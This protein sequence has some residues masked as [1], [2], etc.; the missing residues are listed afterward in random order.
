ML[1]VWVF[2]CTVLTRFIIYTEAAQNIT[3]GRTRASLRVFPNMFL[4][5]SCSKRFERC[6]RVYC[7]L[8]EHVSKPCHQSTAVP[9]RAAPSACS[10]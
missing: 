6:A 8:Y 9:V 5:I 1:C 7:I 10:F 2:G 4:S 3:A